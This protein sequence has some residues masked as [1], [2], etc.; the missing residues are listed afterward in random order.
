MSKWADY[1][2]SAV[3]Y[4]SEHK[5]TLARQHK[6]TGEQIDPKGTIVDRGTIAHNLKNGITYATIYSTLNTWKLGEKIR[7]FRVDNE[8][9]IR[10]DN[11]KVGRDNLGSLP[12]I[13]ISDDGSVIEEIS[14]AKPTP[15]PAPKP[16]AKPTPPPAPKPEAKSDEIEPEVKAKLEQYEARIAEFEKVQQEQLELIEKFKQQIEKLEKAESPRGTLPKPEPIPTPEPPSSPRGSLP[17]DFDPNAPKEEPAATPEQLAK[18]EELEKQIAELETIKEEPVPESLDSQIEGLKDLENQINELES[19]LEKINQP[20][21]KSP[22]KPTS[23]TKV[24]AYCVKC[25]TKQKI[26]NPKQTTMKN[27]RPAI[28]GICS[29]CGT[30]VFRIGKLK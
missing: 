10:T 25:K 4:D 1:L 29:V 26:A 17:K 8:Y 6:D 13:K 3:S 15:P 23:A 14:E 16:E 11:N 22:K 2:I 9:C 12:E 20:K 7:T 21:T 19:S 28:R 5:V 24:E 18:V 30:N 27:G